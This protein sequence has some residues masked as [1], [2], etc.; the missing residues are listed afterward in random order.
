MRGDYDQHE[1]HGRGR[2]HYSGFGWGGAYGGPGEVQAHGGG[3]GG[4]P[5]VGY[6]GGYIGS[7]GY[8]PWYGWGNGPWYGEG[9]PG[10]P[11]P[12]GMPGRHR[13]HGMMHHKRHHHEMGMVGC[14]VCGRPYRWGAVDSRPDQRKA[15]ERYLEDLDDEAQ[16]VRREIERIRSEES[17]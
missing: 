2:K 6:P 16:E 7:Y 17:H 1:G 13:M 5:G 12:H 14:P 4:G 10:M 3:P 8:G 15:L 9:Q 11:G